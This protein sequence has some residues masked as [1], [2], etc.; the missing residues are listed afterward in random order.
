MFIAELQIEP[1]QNHLLTDR[2]GFIFAWLF[3]QLFGW[4]A[5]N[6]S[7]VALAFEDADWWWIIDVG[8]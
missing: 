6:S 8:M 4:D 5:D 3:V 7:D 2:E 1:N